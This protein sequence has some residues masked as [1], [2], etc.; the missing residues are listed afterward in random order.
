MTKPL[1]PSYRPPVPRF[2]IPALAETWAAK[3]AKRPC[4]HPLP[5]RDVLVRGLK[6]YFSSLSW[7]TVNLWLGWILSCLKRPPASA[8]DS[9]LAVPK[10]VPSAPLEWNVPGRRKLRTWQACHC[11]LTSHETDCDQNLGREYV[12]GPRVCRQNGRPSPL[13]REFPRPGLD[14]EGTAVVELGVD[15]STSS[16]TSSQRQV[17]RALAVN[18]WPTMRA[19]QGSGSGRGVQVAQIESPRRENARS[20]R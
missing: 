3:R 9:E 17:R 4:S 8:H 12:V 1:A 15:S 10:G 11:R 2:R 18:S 7:P 19:V 5:E 16:A 14:K 13:L 6:S 20:T